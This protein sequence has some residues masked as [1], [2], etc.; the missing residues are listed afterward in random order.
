[1]SNSMLTMLNFYHAGIV[2]ANED[3]WNGNAT[4]DIV[5]LANY[6]EAIFFI[7]KGA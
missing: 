6:D 5:S 3:I 1:M 4:T 7:V 2:T